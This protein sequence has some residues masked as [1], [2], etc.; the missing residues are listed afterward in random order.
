[1]ALTLNLPSDL[2]EKL[3]AAAAKQGIT[4]SEYLQKVIENLFAQNAEPEAQ[5]FVPPLV[6]LA[7]ELTANI[8]AREIKAIP[9]DLSV[10]GDASPGYATDVHETQITSAEVT[11]TQEQ[12]HPV[13]R[14]AE[15]VRALIPPDERKVIPPDASKNYKHYL[16]G[17]PK[18]EE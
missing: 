18:V 11:P 13:V 8:P 3:A 5:D 4:A 2:E 12:V 10:N 14:L 15:R 9:T 6:R 1:M 7:R 17:H 16:Y